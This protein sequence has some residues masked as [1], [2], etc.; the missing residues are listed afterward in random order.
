MPSIQAR[1]MNFIF[2]CMQKNK[3]EGERDYEAERQRNNRKPPRTPKN[4]TV[5]PV[6]LKGVYGEKIEKQENSKG[7]IFYIHGGDFTTGSAK[8]R[9]GILQYIVDKYGYNSF[10]FDYR[11]APEHKW[12][13]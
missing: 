6:T 3:P 7:W 2:W 8:E 10:G 13:A 4:I 5:T 12:P 11:L 1:F 9:R